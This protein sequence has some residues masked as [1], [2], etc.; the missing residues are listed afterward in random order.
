MNSPTATSYDGSAAPLGRPGAWRSLIDY[1]FGDDTGIGALEDAVAEAAAHLGAPAVKRRVVVAI[2]EPIRYRDVDSKVT[3]Y[4]GSVDGEA[5]DFSDAN[6][7]LKACKWFIDTVRPSSTAENTR[8]SS[9]AGS[10]GLPRRTRIR[11]EFWE[12]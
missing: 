1:C 5:L 12:R 8:M 7:R 2:P 3:R 10:T 11:A 6:D 4:W 9:L